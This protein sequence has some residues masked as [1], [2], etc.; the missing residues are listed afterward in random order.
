MGLDDGGAQVV[1]APLHGGRGAAGG[2]GGEERRAERRHGEPGEQGRGERRARERRDAEHDRQREPRDGERQ[3]PADE[4]VEADVDV[5]GHPGE[6]VPPTPGHRPRH[7]LGERRD[8]PPAPPDDAREPVGVRGDP[9]EVAQHR[10]RD[11]EP[12]HGHHGDRQREDRRLRGGTRDEPRR[13]RGERD[14]GH[15]RAGPEHDGAREPAPGRWCRSEGVP[16]CLGRSEGVPRAATRTRR[17]ATRTRRAQVHDAVGGLAQGRAV[18]DGED[19]RAPA[20]E[21]AELRDDD[22]LRLGIQ[23][24]RG[25]V[26][27]DDGARR[28]G[29]RV[30]QHAREREAAPLPRGQRA[31]G[32]GERQRRVEVESQAPQALRR[33]G[34][35]RLAHGRGVRELGVLAE[36]QEPPPHL[37]R[38]GRRGGV[39]ERPGERPQ[40]RG[41]ARPG[42][43]G[44]DHQLA[45]ARVERRHRRRRLPASGVPH[46]QVAHPDPRGARRGRPRR[47]RAD[48]T[49]HQRVPL[50][51][52]GGGAGGVV[53]P[54]P[55]LAQ[56]TVRLAGEQDRHERRVQRHRALDEPHPGAHRDQADRQRP[57]ELQGGRRQ[58]HHPQHPRRG[59][60]VLLAELLDRRDRPVRATE[61]PQRGEARDRVEEV[62]GQPLPRR[63]LP[64]RPRSRRPPEQHRE[65]RHER[66]R[67]A[68]DQGGRRVGERQHH[69]HGGRQDHREHERRQGRGEPAAQGVDTVRGQRHHGRGVVVPEAVEQPGALALDDPLPGARGHERREPRQPGPHDDHG[70]Q[71]RD[72][73]VRH[74]AGPHDQ[75]RHHA[76]RG[77]RRGH[78]AGRLQDADHD[79]R[80]HASPGAAR[81]SHQTAVHHVATRSLATRRRNTQ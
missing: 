42:R 12:A 71:H 81:Q 53:E 51:Q 59:H 76:R 63:P 25:L 58:E 24:R 49:G 41:L 38:A 27:Q 52:H 7:A 72:R 21:R 65:H 29:V 48:R 8:H 23:V 30:A 26:E 15:R 36:H 20:R 34:A 79:Q 55:G 3:H 31:T 28:I 2:D 32:L 74:A 69:Q 43:P 47:R 60:P 66:Q 67:H 6:Q 57:Q 45:A 13:R 61:Q 37:D 33:G 1:D 50:V 16:R 9:L 62:P 77:Q 44:D 10:A 70:G 73:R 80:A 68:H 14:A 56:R 11:R 64:P 17:A 4:A 18:G 39:V 35:Q 19:Q 40:Q 54:R 5:V 22:T 78:G 75:R 46:G